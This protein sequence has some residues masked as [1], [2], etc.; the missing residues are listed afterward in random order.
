MLS[1]CRYTAATLVVVLSGL[2]GRK[3]AIRPKRYDD[4]N[5]VPNLWGAIVG[6]PGFLKTPALEAVLRPLKRL[7]AEAM[8][9]HGEQLKQFAERQLIAAARRAAAKKALDKAAV[10]KDADDE[11]QVLARD[12]SSDTAEVQPKCR[13][14]TVTDFTVEKLGELLVENSNG[15]TVIRDELTGLLNT[16]S[17]GGP[18]S[19]SWIPARVLEWDGLIHVRSDR[20]AA[21]PK[22]YPPLRALHYSA[23]SSPGR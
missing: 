19:G 9:S 1:P 10:R 12:A 23:P 6:P 8:E 20:A 3:V 17:R 7:V 18:S 16:L 5:V 2:I 15:L 14:L 22:T 11:L 21:L 4:W 13:R